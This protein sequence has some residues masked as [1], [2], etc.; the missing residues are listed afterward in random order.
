MRTNRSCTES[1]KVTASGYKDRVSEKHPSSNKK[2]KYKIR[3][4]GE[5]FCLAGETEWIQQPLLFWKRRGSRDSAS[6]SHKTGVHSVEYDEIQ[7]L[8]HEQ[9]GRREHQENADHLWH[10]E[11]HLD[12]SGFLF[13]LWIILVFYHFSISSWLTLRTSVS[14]LLLNND[15]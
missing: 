2:E 9:T 15:Y 7:A 4:K 12:I 10:D 3:A 1:S 13:R 5:L 8:K 6:Y 11:E 14:G